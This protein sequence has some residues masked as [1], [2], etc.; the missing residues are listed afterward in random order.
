MKVYLNFVLELVNNDDSIIKKYYHL[1]DVKQSITQ[2]KPTSPKHMHADFKQIKPVRKQSCKQVS[3]KNSIILMFSF[4]NEKI[5][6]MT[7]IECF[8]RL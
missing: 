7:V 2:K 8:S 6:L 1:K 3:L 5:M 4:K